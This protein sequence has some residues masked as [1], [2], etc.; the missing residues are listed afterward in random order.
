MNDHPAFVAIAAPPAV[1]GGAASSL[2]EEAIAALKTASTTGTGTIYIYENLDGTEINAGKGKINK[3]D[4]RREVARWLHA[5]DELR[6][7]KLIQLTHESKGTTGYSLTK[8]GYAV[9]D[10]QVVE[11]AL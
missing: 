10:K 6:A 9:A 4:D 7:A 11:D 3:S 8:S 2:S 1:T 5:V